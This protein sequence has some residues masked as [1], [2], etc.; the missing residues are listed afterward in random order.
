[1]SIY[2]NQTPTMD[3]IKMIGT[4][5]I[6]TP[7]E[8]VAFLRA[9]QPINEQVAYVLQRVGLREQHAINREVAK[10]IEEV[11]IEQPAPT[12]E[13]PKEFVPEEMDTDEGY[14]EKEI[15]DRVAKLKSAKALGEKKEEKEKKVEKT[16]K[17]D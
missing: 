16:K 6:T 12:V 5:R 15:E 7:Q 10:P 17:E 13:A 3:Q 1:M 9:I 11:E 4:M 14:S 8:A 2:R